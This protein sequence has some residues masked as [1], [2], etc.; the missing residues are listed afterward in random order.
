VIAAWPVAAVGAWRL[1]RPL[2]SGLGRLVLVVTYLAVPLSYNSLA[3]GHWDGLLVFAAAPWVLVRIARLTGLDPYSVE[4]GDEAVP[5]AGGARPEDAVGQRL[6]WRLAV[7]GLAIGLALVAAL[8]PAALIAVLLMGSGVLAG[9]LFTGDARAA[10]RG[11]G[12]AAAA[13]G[14]AVLL[15]A[16]W[17]L[18]VLLGGGFETITGVAP[19]PAGA[20]G[21]GTLLRFHVGPLGAAPLGWAFLV[22]ALLPLVLGQG[23]RLDW[24]VRCWAMVLLSVAV[25]WAGGRN[26]FPIRT[27]AADVLL[28]PAAI[29]LALA[30]ALGAAAF[31]SDLSRYRFGWRQAVSVVAGVAVT[32]GAMPVLVGAANGRWRLPSTEL[33]RSLAWMAPTRSEGSFRVL[34]LGDPEVLPLGTWNLGDGTAYATSRDGMPVAT[35]LLPGPPSA[36]TR[37]IVAALGEAQRGDTARLG[38]LLAPMAVRYLVLPRQ[39]AAGERRGTQRPPSAAL[40]GALQSQLDLRLLPSD[41]AAVVYENTAWGPG[42]VLRPADDPTVIAGSVADGADLRG[43]TPVLEGT[44]PVRFAGELP[45]GGRVLVSEAPSSRWELTVGGREASRETAF[46]VANAYAATAGGDGTLRYRTPLWRYAALLIQVALWVGAVRALLG[47][48]RRLGR[49]GRSR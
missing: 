42:R 15:L 25:A 6:Q 34:W 7:I 16:P 47:L 30:A 28:V 14:G 40:T 43:G 12:G 31:E 32:I 2:G 20:P 10:A 13:V 21:L 8:A 11:L 22:A 3:R 27:Q 23:W 17:S 48:R 38:R 36:A 46:G 45:S 44:G 1:G 5:D 24:A 37:R 26:W 41:P 49:A 4:D 33:A 19:S 18:E 39:L 9:S 29:G 35:D